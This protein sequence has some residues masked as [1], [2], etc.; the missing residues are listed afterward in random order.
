LV[1]EAQYLAD[2]DGHGIEVYRDRPRDAW[3]DRAGRF[4]MDTIRLDVAGILGELQDDEP[5]WAG[6]TEGTDM[7]HVHLQVA[8]IAATEKFYIGVLGME[9][10][11]TYPGASFVSAGGYHHHLGLNIWAGAG[12][13]PPPEHAAR[14]LS[15]ELRVPSAAGFAAVLD[16]VRAAGLALTEQEHGW[17]VRDPAQ[18]TVV[19]RQF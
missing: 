8:D 12:V 11:T 5:D 19:L 3:V 6:L 1:S 2:P 16:R 18:N 7:G 13:P 17:A 15:Y 14:L 10:M 9:R 4:R